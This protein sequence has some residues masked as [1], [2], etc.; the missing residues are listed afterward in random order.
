MANTVEKTESLLQKWLLKLG[1]A[2][3]V[4]GTLL[5]TF[6]L[7]VSF[8]VISVP[9]V[10]L[11]ITPEMALFC[12]QAVLIL[13]REGV[14]ALGWI[15]EVVGWRKTADDNTKAGNLLRGSQLLLALA[16]FFMYAYGHIQTFAETIAAAWHVAQPFATNAGLIVMA[17]IAA[18][19]PIV[20]LVAGVLGT[21]FYASKTIQANKAAKKAQQDL[22]DLNNL[23]PNYYNFYAVIH[24]PKAA[25]NGLCKQKSKQDKKFNFVDFG[26]YVTTRHALETTVREKKSATKAYAFWTAICV[27]GLGIGIA[28]LI[29]TFP[30]A[31]LV[32]AGGILVLKIG[33]IVTIG[34]ITLAAAGFYAHKYFQ[35]RQEKKLVEKDKFIERKLNVIAPIEQKRLDHEKAQ[36]LANNKSRVTTPAPIPKTPIKLAENR[37]GFYDK[38]SP[39]N[40]APTP[41]GIKNR[42]NRI[43]GS[44]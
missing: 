34:L 30:P 25:I 28:A 6:W 26:K 18:F 22:V 41:S 19:A 14:P 31:G 33:I 23:D 21:I 29:M 36:R 20:N 37:Y 32:A 17:K 27:I 24:T 9:L 2:F 3:D 15:S 7:L 1:P 5:T 8:A 40:K 39:K 4:V 35:Q 38:K 13:P 11:G 44:N 12:N 43:A 42:S 10:A 16:A